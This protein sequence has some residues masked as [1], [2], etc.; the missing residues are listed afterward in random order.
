MGGAFVADNLPERRRSHR[1][2][3][4]YA[5]TEHGLA[6]PRLAARRQWWVILAVFAVVVAATTSSTNTLGIA[7]SARSRA[8]V[9]TIRF[10]SLLPRAKASR[11]T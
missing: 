5:E 3:E 11:A 7:S 6:G 8:R 10:T 2:M 1:R 4:F 9:V